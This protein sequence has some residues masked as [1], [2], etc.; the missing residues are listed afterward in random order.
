MLYTEEMPDYG[1]TG[2]L[3]VPPTDFKIERFRFF[4]ETALKHGIDLRFCH[5]KNPG[6]TKDLCHEPPPLEARHTVQGRLFH[7]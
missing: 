5:C 3:R 2:I 7:E 4:R 6:A 1:Q